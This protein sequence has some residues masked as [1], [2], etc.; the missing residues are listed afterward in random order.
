MSLS[1]LGQT[2]GLQK[3]HGTPETYFATQP[4]VS[5]PAA[6]QMNPEHLLFIQPFVNQVAENTLAC[7]EVRRGIE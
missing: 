6:L 3:L 5:P 4:R 7:E 1:F 2:P